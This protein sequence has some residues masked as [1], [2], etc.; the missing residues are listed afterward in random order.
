M[1]IVEQSA[2]TRPTL[3]GASAPVVVARRGRRPDELATEPLVVATGEMVVDERSDQ[4]AQVPLAEDDELVEAFGPDGP[5][6]ALSVRP[7]VRTMCWDG[8]ALHSSGFEPSSAKTRSP[9]VWSSVVVARKPSHGSPRLGCAPDDEHDT[10][11]AACSAV[12]A[13]AMR[14]FPLATGRAMAVTH[15]LLRG[16]PVIVDHSAQ[17]GSCLDVARFLRWRSQLRV[18]IWNRVQC[19]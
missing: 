15:V 17:N 16:S 13:F 9:E 7:A 19:S 1:R 10:V 14:T 8:H 2:E 12:K 11:R 3:N 4:L 6:E 18:W 5:H